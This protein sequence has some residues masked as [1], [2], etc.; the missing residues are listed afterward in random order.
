MYSACQRL[1]KKFAAFGASI[2]R[3]DLLKDILF[4]G[5][6]I[7]VL[8]TVL[9]IPLTVAATITTLGFNDLIS[10]LNKGRWLTNPEAI[11][12]VLYSSDVSSY[13]FPTF[14]ENEDADLRPDFFATH[15]TTVLRTLVSTDSRNR[16]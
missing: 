16:N 13:V 3:T 6:L 2:Y 4:I 8:D 12:V 7:Q 9:T 14:P 10:L 1:F 11:A 5:G 15:P